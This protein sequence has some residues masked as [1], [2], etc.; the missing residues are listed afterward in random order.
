M[1]GKS[2]V[3][4]EQGFSALAYRHLG[5]H[6]AVLGGCPGHYRMFASIPEHRYPPLP[7]LVTAKNVS[8][9]C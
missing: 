8:G 6:S 4:S 5:L 9:P 7:Q 2:L 3:Y 1:R